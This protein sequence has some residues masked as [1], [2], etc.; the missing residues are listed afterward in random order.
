LGKKIYS[1]YAAPQLRRDQ[2]LAEALQGGGGL[3][4]RLVELK[5]TNGIPDKFCFVSLRKTKTK[6]SGMTSCLS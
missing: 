4:S 3:E 5:K 6:F 2:D 1:A